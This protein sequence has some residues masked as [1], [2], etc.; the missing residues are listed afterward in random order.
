MP[1]SGSS[2]QIVESDLQ[3]KGHGN[4]TWSLAKKPYKIKLSTKTGLLGMP[5]QKNWVL[6]PDFDDK[7]MLRVDVA[8]ELSRRMKM[9][10]TPQSQFVEAFLNGEYQGTYQLTE[11]IEIDKNRLNIDSLGGKDVTAPKVTGGYL[12]EVDYNHPSDANFF[13]GGVI[14]VQIHDPDPMA[15]AQQA[16]IHDYLEQV[17]KTLYGEYFADPVTG[18]AQYLDVDSFVD[19]YL[20]NE[21]FK[22]NDAIWWSSVYM[23]KARDGKLYCGPVW[24]FDLGAGN[25]VMNNTADPTG[26]WVRNPHVNNGQ[27]MARLF[28]DPAFRAKVK[29]R[30]NELKASQFDTLTTYID[31]RAVY[32]NQ[33]QQNNF[34]RWPVLETQVLSEPEL[35]GSYSGEVSY[36]KNWLTTRI[37][38]MDSQINSDTF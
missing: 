21:I 27:W 33:T 23:Y 32:L 36:M 1:A 31:Q 16:Y 24:D 17:H 30:W 3:I 25:S 29:A 38:W 9:A 12:I 2:G 28:E 15:P 22:N 19:W 11:S 26:W 14:P 6:L 8:F 13:T 5:A 35:A 4:T 18:Y 34:A 7:T 20:V 37:A 10:Y